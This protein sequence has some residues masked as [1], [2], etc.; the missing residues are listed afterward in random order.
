M[1]SS[2]SLLQIKRLYCLHVYVHDAWAKWFEHLPYSLLLPPSP[3]SHFTGV[4]MARF[5]LNISFHNVLSKIVHVCHSFEVKSM[6]MVY[7][8]KLNGKKKVIKKNKRKN[9]K[10]TMPKTNHQGDGRL[11]CWTLMLSD[12]GNYTVIPMWEW[13][14][15]ITVCG[16][17]EININIMWIIMWNM[18]SR[19]VTGILFQR[20]VTEYE[21]T[22]TEF[23]TN[24]YWTQ[25]K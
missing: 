11:Y 18:H 20:F 3:P 7:W 1:L 6:P 12:R 13:V 22:L 10:N 24:N 14:V 17:Y 25:V 2:L 19:A 9:N 16:N 4:K 5:S 23:T 15:I 8:K 21:K